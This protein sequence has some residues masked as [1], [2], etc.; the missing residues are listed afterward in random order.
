MSSNRFPTLPDPEIIAPD[1][2][3]TLASLKERYYARTGHYPGI[4]DPETPHLEQIAYEKS[5]A[6]DAINYESKQNL[7]AF[8]TGPRLE[9]LAVTVGA[10]ERLGESNAS[11]VIQLN[12]SAGHASDVIPQGW[13]MMAA[14]G[15]TL[16]E[17]S[18]DYIV[19]P[20]MTV[21][22]ANFECVTGG[23]EGNGFIAGQISTIVSNDI[24]G[25]ISAENVT[26]S[27]GGAPA[28]DDDAYAYRIWLAPSSWAACGPYDAYEYFALSASSAIASV[29]IWT[30]EPNEINISAILLDGSLPEQPIKDAILAECSG[31]KRVPMGDLVSVVDVTETIGTTTIALSVYKDYAALGKTIIDTATKAIEAELLTWRTTHGH[32][33]VVQ[34]LESI[35]KTIEGV[36]YAD[37]HIYDN[38]GIEINSIQSLSKKERA[39]ITLTSMTHVVVDE[40]SATNFQ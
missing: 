29:S 12:F 37:V 26:T 2:E 38:D 1:Y 24:D 40:Y 33:I 9:N 35:C 27:Q 5:E 23:E 28:E 19:D 39:N 20:D 32:D 17:C 30:P 8:A 15:Q 31:E 10:G 7:P 4:N 36:Y 34:T 16:F 13:Q 21:V 22:L 25:L 6:I 3:A 11:T 18:Q 14:D